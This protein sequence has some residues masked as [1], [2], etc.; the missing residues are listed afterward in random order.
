[1]LGAQQQVLRGA[2]NAAANIGAGLLDVG[3]GITDRMLGA[4][5]FATGD[6]Q[7]P[8][9]M[10][11]RSNEMREGFRQTN[12]ARNQRFD[13]TATPL[14]RGGALATEVASFA[15]PATKIDKAVRGAGMLTRGAAQAAGAMGLDTAMQAGEGAEEQ[16]AGRTA[17]TGAAAFG[18]EMIAPVFA[19]IGRAG[20]RA[21]KGRADNPVEVGRE[22]ARRAGIDDIP[23]DVAQ[24]LANAADEIEAG[25]RP[26]AVLA[27]Q[28]FGFRLTR[29][30]KTGSF[31]DLAREDILRQTNA[32]RRLRQVDEAN[33]ENLDQ[34]VSRAT[35]GLDS[36]QSA[37][38]DVAA[39]IR[40]A[41][42]QARREA[43]DAWQFAK[44]SDLVVSGALADDFSRNVENA[45]RSE[46]RIV[47]ENIA[48]PARAA[49]QQID[50]VLRSAADS[51]GGIDFKK[52]EEARKMFS[53]NYGA[54]SDDSSRAA[55]RIAR[56][57]FDNTLDTL[58][59]ATILR[60]D[61]QDIQRMREAIGIS[62]D[63]FKK[64]S[65][66]G[67][68]D[69]VGKTVE[70]ILRNGNSD[71]LTAALLGAGEVAPRAGANFARAVKR[72]LGDNAPELERVKQAVL[73]KAA[74]RNTGDSV[75]M[76]RLSSNL[77]N[78]MRNRRDLMKE[79]FDANEIRRLDRMAQAL[80]S[81]TQKP[82]MIG[83]SS[84]TT[85]RAIRAI[86][87]WA[88]DG[89]L[90]AI[91]RMMR[92]IGDRRAVRSALAPIQVTA[93]APAIP[94]AAAAGASNR[95]SGQ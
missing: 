24:R 81:M 95:P 62:R 18:A 53:T 4:V 92:S 43:G 1:M 55:L 10:R 15:V 83:R 36:P 7:F 52:I 65:A 49:I 42:E 2:T 56:E 30:Q 5:D 47:N 22:I 28:E 76:Q 54:M 89:V 74:T 84:G 75:G 93:S 77:K 27:E 20:I 33:T 14:E 45:F 25:A 66:S 29:G 79:L 59:E 44:D 32:G 72:T 80:D 68:D 23:D 71:D 3:A 73:L 88:G 26:E 21:I 40:G 13:E 69:A 91:P 82:G 31:D 64:F 35:G 60:G 86:E 90:G 9:Q 37:V 63:V 78:L 87:N 11:A 48:A 50:D 17:L 16:D 12:E 38:D 85:E 57:Q 8:E 70:K 67:T 34:I 6:W 61:P 19:R 41:R 39:S 51:T 58:A 46:G 94:A